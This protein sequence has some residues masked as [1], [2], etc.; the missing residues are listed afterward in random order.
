MGLIGILLLNGCRSPEFSYATPSARLDLS[1]PSIVVLPLADSRT[2]READHVF[3]KGYL[4]NVQGEVGRELQSMDVFSSVAVTTNQE[5]F[6]N[7]DLQLSLTLQRLDCKVPHHGRISTEKAALSVIDY[8]VGLPVGG[9]Y[10]SFS[11][12][13][14]GNSALQVAVRRT[15]DQKLLFNTSYSETVTNRVKKSVCNKPQTKAT[16]MLAAFQNTQAQLKGDLLK[17]IL[18]EKYANAASGNK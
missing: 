11:T 6:P 1:G 2:N 12:S 8:T 7:A 18:Q 10:S 3:R 13:V 17:E 16:V 15:A 4:A 9:I 14:Y 5:H